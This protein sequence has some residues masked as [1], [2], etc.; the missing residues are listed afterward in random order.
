MANFETWTIN[1]RIYKSISY[2][3]TTNFLLMYVSYCYKVKFIS[4]RKK[5]TWGNLGDSPQIGDRGEWIFPKISG[6]FPGSRNLSLNFRDITG[7]GKSSNKFPR[8]RD[9]AHGGEGNFI[10]QPGILYPSQ[11]WIFPWSV[12]K[13]FNL[14]N[15]D[16]LIQLLTV[17][18]R[19][20]ERKFT[21]PIQ[22]AIL[23]TILYY[24]SSKLSA[25]LPPFSS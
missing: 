5:N 25:L 18:W 14:G 4:W 1:L 11:Q 22:V 20:I 6:I 15:S 21:S 24:F 16:I 12:T 2:L 23:C 3:N 10:L 7:T 8:S 17:Q 13:D 9:C 19:C